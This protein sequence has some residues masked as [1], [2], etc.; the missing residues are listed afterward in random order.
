MSISLAETRV[1]KTFVISS[2]LPRIFEKIR[3][4]SDGMA[5]KPVQETQTTETP[6]ARQKT[7][8]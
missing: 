7:S 6:G 4:S 5:Q 8:I 1:A 2:R 3:A